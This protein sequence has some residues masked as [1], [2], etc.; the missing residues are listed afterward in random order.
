MKGMREGVV[1]PLTAVGSSQDPGTE[2]TTMLL[3][4]TPAARSLAF[5]PSS[6]GWMMVSFQR[7]WTMPMRR[8]LPSWTWGAGPLVSVN[9]LGE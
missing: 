7:A 5:V 2:V 8:P 4:F 9:I 6:R 1:Y 3:S